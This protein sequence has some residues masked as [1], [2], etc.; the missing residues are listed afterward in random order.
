MSGKP[1]LTDDDALIADVAAAAEATPSVLTAPASAQDSTPSK[2]A[3]SR[4]KGKSSTKFD[5]LFGDGDDA[6]PFSDKPSAAK[7]AAGTKTSLI[8]SP[9]PAVSVASLQP[10]RLQGFLTK[11]GG[12]FKSWKKRWFVLTDNCLYYFS[13]QTSAKCLGMITLPSYRPMAAEQEMGKKHGF[14]VRAGWEANDRALFLA[15]T[16]PCGPLAARASQRPYVL[17]RGDHRA[18]DGHVDQGTLHCVPPGCA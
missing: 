15:H 1:D 6:D 17:F 11:Q 7:K 18:R 10:C 12:A 13:S 14:K 2:A 5:E 8:A 9:A 16:P 3:D 4:K